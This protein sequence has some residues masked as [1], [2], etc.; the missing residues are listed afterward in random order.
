[1]L[2]VVGY[3]DLTA[4][5]TAAL[6]AELAP[7]LADLGVSDGLKPGVIERSCVPGA[8]ASCFLYQ[9]GLG[10]PWGITVR[11]SLPPDRRLANL[12]YQVQDWADE[13]LWTAGSD[14]PWPH[15]AEHPKAHPLVPAVSGHG[16]AV[17]RCPHTK[18]DVCPIGSLASQL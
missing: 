16:D 12:A 9:E 7:V 4:A 17:W 10:G 15:C 8:G 6:H 1:V 2:R 14:I 18:S 13:A 3:R 11:H 5:E